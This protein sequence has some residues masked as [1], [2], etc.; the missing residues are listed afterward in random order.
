MWIYAKS[1][2]DSYLEDLLSDC[3][4]ILFFLKVLLTN[5]NICQWTSPPI[6][7]TLVLN[8]DFVFPSLF[9][10]LLFGIL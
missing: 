5:F 6:V 7:I 8:G 4:D 2:M 9:L 1:I 3:V 10:H